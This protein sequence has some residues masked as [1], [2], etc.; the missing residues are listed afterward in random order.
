MKMVAKIGVV[1][2]ALVAA[3]GVAN[4]DPVTLGF[5]R[6]TNNASVDPAS[7]F[8]VVVSDAGSGLV[9]FKFLNNVGIAS[10]ITDV[11]FEDGTLLA[12][13]QITSSA[14]VSFSEGASP[15]NLPGGSAV[16]FVATTGFTA[17]SD[18]PAAPNGVNSASEWLTIRYSLQGGQTFDDTIASLNNGS[19]RIGMHVQAIGTEGESDGFVN[20]VVIPLP[21]TA[22]LALAGLGAVAIRRRRK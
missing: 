1:A 16:G 2:L 4:A 14:G 18:P 7:Q 6:I 5:T 3:C 10:S 12:I 17:D 21:T 13:A 9:D 20:T 15:G 8:S 19:L 22:G 11:Y